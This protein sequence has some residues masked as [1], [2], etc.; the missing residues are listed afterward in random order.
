MFHWSD[1][2]EPY[3]GGQKAPLGGLKDAKLLAT[4][5]R[6]RRAVAKRY[7]VV[8][9][10]QIERVLPPGALFISTKVDGELW[11]L[12]KRGDDVALATYNGR[13]LRGGPVFQEVVGQ[14]KGSGDLVIA[15]ELFAVP[16]GE[17]RARV[18]HVA[19]ALGDPSLAATLGFRA[20]D[21]VEDGTDD[22]LALPYSK[23]LERL[24]KIFGKGDKARVVTTV[25]GEAKDAASYYREWV[26]TQQ[27]EGI[28]V[29]TEQGLTFKIKPTF[30][31]DAVVI[32]FGERIVNGVA[33]VRELSVA[34]RRDDGNLQLLG[35]VGNG[36]SEEG[37]VEW[38]QR[39]TKL[40]VPSSFRMA[41]RE[42][43]LCRFVKPEIVVEIQ[44]SDLLETDS[45]DQVIRRV[46]LT[47]DP[48]TGYASRGDHPIA[49][50][51]FPI[52]LRERTDKT[53]DVASI[54]MQ[55]VT[56]RLPLRADDASTSVENLPPS[57]IVKRGVYTKD[58]KG[59]TAV[60]K[61][62]VI[63]THKAQTKQYPPFALYFTDYSAGRKE[64][65]QTSVRS[66]SSLERADVLVRAWIEENVK[67]G[68]VEVGATAV[69]A[70]PPEPA[71]TDEKKPTK[72]RGGK[73]SEAAD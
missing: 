60:R 25:A 51:L 28:V 39:L 20:F 34:L 40:V 63:E 64:P 54:G 38:L 1:S 42:G 41:N 32:A 58:A 68:W 30:T 29:R 4:F 3:A 48:A 15:G 43:T 7:R 18:G 8:E 73:S 72:K 10:A 56:S 11:F 59:A 33:Q 14:L 6:Y 16:T 26:G 62:V 65:L 17:G 13:V 66:A 53:A 49:A 52:F 70:A 37:R 5:D 27:F 22:G 46:A 61:Y 45:N 36:F 31:L 2:F 57:Q 12:V 50:M 23:R 44:L 9:P 71:P 21:L 35:T 24:E 55:Q 47:Y 19:K 67:K 69:A